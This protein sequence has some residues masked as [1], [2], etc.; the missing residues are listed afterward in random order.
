[1]QTSLLGVFH[2]LASG[3]INFYTRP[4]PSVAFFL[5]V[6]CGTNC[7]KYI[8]PIFLKIMHYQQLPCLYLILCLDT[9]IFVNNGKTEDNDNYNIVLKDESNEYHRVSVPESAVKFLLPFHFE[10][11]CWE[12]LWRYELHKFCFRQPNWSMSREDAE[13][14][15][16][17]S[18][19]YHTCDDNIWKYPIRIL[20]GQT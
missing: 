3:K 16:Y 7:K 1:M 20:T 2:A 13:L 4:C 10:W 8:F 11:P 14:V 9:G 12:N 18:N 17:P 6:Q 19:H 5:P 15:E